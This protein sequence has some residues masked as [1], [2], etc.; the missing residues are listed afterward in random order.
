MIPLQ[1]LEDLLQENDQ[2]V[3]VVFLLAMAQHAGGDDEAAS[4]TI[5]AGEAL[6]QRLQVPEDDP[7]VAGFSQL[8]AIPL[9]D[10]LL[11]NSTHRF[12][13]MLLALLLSFCW[14]CCCCEQRPPRA[15]LLIY[16]I[17]GSS[18]EVEEARGP[19]EACH[20]GED[21]GCKGGGMS[22]REKRLPAVA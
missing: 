11:A 1:I 12:L 22:L 15:M 3:H 6:M 21:T 14:P 5:T 4:E 13:G 20:A 19:K 17:L 8:K 10:C 9:F 18:W 7:A 16:L 2:A